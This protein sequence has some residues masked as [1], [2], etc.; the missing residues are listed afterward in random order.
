MPRIPGKVFHVYIQGYNHFI[1][2]WQNG[3]IVF[4]SRDRF[5]TFSQSFHKLFMYWRF[6]TI[7][8][9]NTWTN[10][11]VGYLCYQLLFQGISYFPCVTPA[12][13]VTSL[14]ISNVK[15]PFQ[16]CK[17]NTVEVGHRSITLSLISDSRAVDISSGGAAALGQWRSVT[18]ARWRKHTEER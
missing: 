8:Q 15:S 5:Q 3:R 6:V 13:P 14:I 9:K 11:D 12:P 17:L 7:P 1:R 18:L 10:Y 2:K 16:R 4:W